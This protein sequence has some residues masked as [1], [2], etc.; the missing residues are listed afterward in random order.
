[1]RRLIGLLLCLALVSHLWASEERPVLPLWP[2]KPPGVVPE[3]PEKD[4][5]RDKDNQVA[6]KRVMRLGGITQPSVTVFHP[7]QPAP[8]RPAVVVC[9]GGGY[10]I[11]AWDL[12]G[13]EVCEWL[14]SL[15][16]TGVLL[17]YRVPAPKTGP[18]HASALMDAQR[19]VRLVRS[20]AADW[21]I[22]PKKV[23]ILGFSAG[24]HLATMTALAQ[25]ESTYEPIDAIDKLSARPDFA[26]LIYPAYLT[27]PK[28]DALA[29][30]VTV[31]KQTPPMF[32]AHAG[33]DPVPAESSVLLYLAL[34]KAGVKAELH[35][36][37]RGGHGYGLRR[38][39]LP[40]ADW[41]KRCE[42]WLRVQGLLAKP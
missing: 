40:V 41:P 12:E 25:Q 15:G 11:L 7:S 28:R 42:E 39:G 8:G 16:I 37:D 30:N 36:Y 6:G 22:D 38:T 33:D 27:T 34:K 3:G 18:R 21:Q 19:A 23:G 31:T 24:G 32:L 35:V 2:G 14:N 10:N 20:R 4:I 9:P 5:T 17:K 1:M 26:V 29:D 13:T